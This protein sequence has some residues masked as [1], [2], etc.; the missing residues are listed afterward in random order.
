[1]LK[2]IHTIFQ[3][4]LQTAF[5]N[6]CIGCGEKNKLLCPVCLKKTAESKK[7][8][9]L[10]PPF[11]DEMIICGNYDNQVLRKAV[12]LL[13]YHGIYLMA[14]PLSELLDREIRP[15]LR[16]FENTFLIPIPL[17]ESKRISRGYN[18]SELL[19]K[20]FSE[21]IELHLLADVLTKSKPTPSQ[22]SLTKKERTE[23]IKNSFSVINPEKIS[24]KTIILID[25][26][27]TTG[28]TISEAAKTLK[29]SGAKKVIGLVVARG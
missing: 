7:A 8:G 12:R 13:K 24:G 29:N 2:L 20:S 27:M 18:Q 9:V 17:H 1:M 15:K 6:S 10:Q 25:D 26:I 4:I 21:K 11:T 3:K 22:I 28:A 19:A 14:E 23:N 16:L 5:P